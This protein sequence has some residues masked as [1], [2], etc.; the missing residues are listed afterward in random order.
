MTVLEALDNR[1]PLTF[2]K[3]KKLT[4]LSENELRKE[5]N[6][7]IKERKIILDDYHYF[8]V[9]QGTIEAKN[10]IY[11]FI[12]PENKEKP[13]VYLKLN[14]KYRDG[15]I[16]TFFRY[17][18][19]DYDGNPKD[20]ATV[21]KLLERTKNIVVGK[22]IK[23]YGEL[24]LVERN[25]LEKHRIYKRYSNNALP[26]MICKAEYVEGK[27]DL[28]I[29]EIIGNQDDPGV[30]IAAIAAS[31]GFIT[32]FND[33]VK[34]ELKSIPFELTEEDLKKRK[35]Y[36][37]R[38]IFTI[39]GN[40]SK[41]FDD[42]VSIVKVS[43]NLYELGVYIADVSHY[44]RFNSA[45][46]DEAF[47]RTTSV[48]LANKVIPMLPH[49]LSNGICSLNEGVYRNVL[50]CIMIID[51]EGKTKDY[52]IEEGIIKSCHRMTYDD[53]NQILEGNETLI[54]KYNDIYESIKLM[55]E[56]HLILR[57]R[58]NRKGALEFE[59]DEY[60]FD[61]NEDGSPKSI[62]LRERKEA[63][64]I[65]EDFMIKA[66]EVVATHMTN[67]K[68]PCLY[69]VHESPD[70]DK[71]KQVLKL[72]NNMGIDTQIPRNDIKPKIIQ[73]TLLKID[74][75][76]KKHILNNLLLRSM[77]KAKYQPDNLGHYGLALENY[78]HFTSPIRRYPDLI[79]HRIIKELI[80]HPDKYLECYNYYHRNLPEIGLKTSAG[81]RRSIE[82]EREVNDMLTSW[83]MESKVNS[84]FKGMITSIT[85]FGMFV[86]IDDG[87]EGL[88][89]I[90][91]MNSDYFV[92][93]EDNLRLVSSSKVYNL[94]DNV[95][96]VCIA[97]DRFTNK[98]DFM[99]KE[100]YIRLQRD[101]EGSSNE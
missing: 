38:L 45:L 65:I 13:D 59:V 25:T 31:Y 47:K 55:N 72:I 30:E 29:T 92:Y 33:Q 88:V 37:D 68:L 39:D 20:Y 28:K 42:A 83:Y 44:V 86:T 16:V 76:P 58:S 8:I 5:I 100:D 62:I 95:E 91:N 98:V 64:K 79:L 36:D 67:T 48:Y 10:N 35:I 94:G 49:E 53:V 93:D 2:T 74:N 80:I 99:L 90:R 17:R 69:R 26:N 23:E 19:Y 96:V 57:E 41:D 81:E 73:N 51:S 15:D 61:L 1:G 24:Y 82:C 12:I 27:N 11:G 3:L 101:Y 9:E 6:N 40:D 43:D 60:R 85:S 46:D 50:A 34:E 75:S 77:M 21:I 71:L 52:R 32:E 14:G 89:H 4:K 56:L 84:I 7:L 66:N 78:A 54:N 87:I 18:D 70:Q 22:I 63:E 97:S